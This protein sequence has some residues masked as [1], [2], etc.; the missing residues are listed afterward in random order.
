M[1]SRLGRQ[2]VQRQHTGQK[3]LPVLGADHRRQHATHPDPASLDRAVIHIR[4][5]LRDEHRATEQQGQQANF[6]RRVIT[7]RQT[8]A[9]SMTA[10]LR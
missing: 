7:W 10:E 5:A 1:R 3:H 2:L 4:E 8:T 9:R 6:T